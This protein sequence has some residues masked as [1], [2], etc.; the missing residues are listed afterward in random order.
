MADIYQTLEQQRVAAIKVVWLSRLISFCFLPLVFLPF[1]VLG[2]AMIKDQSSG[3][4]AALAQQ[5]QALIQPNFNLVLLFC[6]GWLLAGGWLLGRYFRR[7]G[8]QPGWDYLQR[9]KTEVFA[10][11]CEQHFPELRYDP[12]GYIGYDIFDALQLFEH[13]SDWYRS[14]DYFSGRQGK[15]DVRFAE[16]HAKRER[17]R[18]RDGRLEKYN[19]TFFHG[20]VFIADF[21]KHFH[22]TARLVPTRQKLPKVRGQAQVVLED[23]DFQERFQTVASDQT[24]IRY[25]LSTSM[26]QRFMHLARRYPNF[27]ARFADDELTLVL[28]DQREHFEPSLYRPAGSQD[29]ISRFVTDI[30]ALLA[31]VDEL[32]L[33]T[34]IWSRS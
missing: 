8:L 15:T 6:L 25:L 33:N 4:L 14:E 23:P 5:L 10:N 13:T 17:T 3:R 16:V 26:M 21:H 2:F 28:P 22:C 20:L 30:E 7:R 1:V 32:D 27:R 29:Q 12:K 19:E 18:M 24:D 9:Y 11:L 31:I 34:R